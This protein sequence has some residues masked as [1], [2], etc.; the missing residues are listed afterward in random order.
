MEY[1]S[2]WLTVSEAA[3]RLGISRTSV[4]GR[5]KR[6]T[7]RTM[8]D[9][10]GNPLVSLE[11]P[12]SGAASGGVE[13][14]VEAPPGQSHDSADPTPLMSLADVRLLLGE[15][16]AAHDRAIAALQASHNSALLAHNNAMAAVYASHRDAMAM[17]VERVD[18]A[19]I[20]A[21]RVE[22]RLDQ[23]LDQLLADRRQPVANQ[24]EHGDRLPW[25][26]RWFGSFSK[27][28]MGR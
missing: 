19:E 13:A 24:V 17:M 26:R 11:A 15:Q 14:S 16:Q 21:E 1:E 27:S 2:E 3:R 6:R 7:L 25:W 5:I 28:D 9:N 8:T 12:P 18:A 23:V 22:Q 10:H 4:R 20:R